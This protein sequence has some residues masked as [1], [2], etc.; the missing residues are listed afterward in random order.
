MLF[1]NEVDDFGGGI[2]IIVNPSYKLGFK[3]YFEPNLELE[4]LYI[5]PEFSHRVYSKYIY[6]KDPDGRFS[7]RKNLDER[8]FNDIKILIGYQ[9]ISYLSLIHI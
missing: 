3:Y 5:S 7:D 8:I 1:G 2:E 4:G 6:E 9:T